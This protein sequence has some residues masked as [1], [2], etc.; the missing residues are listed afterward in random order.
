MAFVKLD[1]GI[2]D[3]T[4][5]VDRDAREVFLTALL[6]AEPY[7][8]MEELPQFEVDSFETT[9]WIVPPDW[10]GIVHA[11]AIGI[12]RR[13]G[14]SDEA[15]LAALKRLGDPEAGSRSP[16][17]EGRRLVRVTGG[18]LVLNFQK[19]RDR[20][21][22]SAERSRRYRQRKLTQRDGVTS[23]RDITQAEAEAEA[24]ENTGEEGFALTQ[25]PDK[26]PTE[27]KG[28]RIPEPFDVS[29]D[30]LAWAEQEVPWLDTDK[31]TKEFVDYWR[32]VPGQ[33]GRKLDWDATWRNR[34]RE[35]DGWGKF[36]KPA[37][38]DPAADNRP[39]WFKNVV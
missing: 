25:P 3:S 27:K 1:C 19:Y 37:T 36:Q 20:D 39:A 6:M 4:L 21:Y 29:K 28:T 30:L 8:T 2:L 14:I 16:E 24:K 32:G 15:G 11:A 33:K 31:A 23:R 22:T 12:I 10:Y 38:A 7:E 13:S 26:P 9:G 34:M 35:L 5:W 17:Y 18:F